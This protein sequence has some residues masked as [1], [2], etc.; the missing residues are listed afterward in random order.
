MVEIKSNFESGSIEVV[1]AI[2]AQNINVNINKDN[3]SCTRQWFYFS[4]ETEEPEQHVICFCNAADV[5]FK[6]AWDGY[7]VMASYDQENWFRVELSFNGQTATV[8]HQAT[9]KMVYY[10]YFT[11]YTKKRQSALLDEIIQYDAV[12]NEILT[13]TKLENE[14]ILTRIGTDSDTTKKVWVIAR[15]HPGETMA[16]WIVEGLT[17]EILKDQYQNKFMEKYTFYIVMNMNPDGSEIGNH[18]TNSQGKNLNR[19]WADPCKETCPEV[20]YVSKAMQKYGVDYF[21]DL[22]GDETI[23]Y[24]FIMSNSNLDRDSLFKEQLEKLDQNFQ[25]KWDYDTYEDVFGGSCCPSGCAMSMT[26]TRYVA[27]NFS[28]SSLLLEA[29]YKNLQN[30]GAIKH[31]DDVG[32]LNLGANLIKAF[33]SLSS[34]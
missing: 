31:W 29:S 17:K 7:Q 19:C 3:Q 6:G 15:Q 22:H 16:Q 30:D 4:V 28:A 10:A 11:P 9:H 8:K 18:R 24:N 27:D 5:T 34:N 32:C 33:A 21:I 12:R 23:P 2:D 20:Y 13:H 25:N 14:L 26:A 1:S